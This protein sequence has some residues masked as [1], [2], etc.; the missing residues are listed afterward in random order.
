M[1]HIWLSRPSTKAPRL[2]AVLALPRV[3]PRIL[4]FC[5]SFGEVLAMRWTAVARFNTHD[6]SRTSLQYG[7]PAPCGLHPAGRAEGRLGLGT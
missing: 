7:G 2:H 5:F 1:S 6:V 3:A 4:F